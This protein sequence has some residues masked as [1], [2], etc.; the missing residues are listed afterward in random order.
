MAGRNINSVIRAN[1]ISEER[2]WAHNREIIVYL[3]QERTVTEI[4]TLTSLGQRKVRA[5]KERLAEFRAQNR[6]E[7]VEAS[8]EM[9]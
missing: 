8:A 6:N 4:A 7:Q 5:I 1:T 9:S 2:W 3:D